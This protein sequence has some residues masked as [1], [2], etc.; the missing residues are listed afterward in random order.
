MLT[1]VIIPC[2]DGED[3]DVPWQGKL[4]QVQRMGCVVIRYRFIVP[5]F[6]DN[7][8]VSSTK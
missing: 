8:P 4:I 2:Y 7:D 3:I 5:F 6:I 1:T